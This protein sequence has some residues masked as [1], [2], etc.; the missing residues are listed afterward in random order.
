M[1]FKSFTK[2]DLRIR[3][4][5]DYICSGVFV[6]LMLSLF[7]IKRIIAYK[8]L[9]AGMISVFKHCFSTR[10][11]SFIIHGNWIASHSLFRCLKSLGLFIKD[12]RQM[13]RTSALI[14]VMVSSYCFPVVQN[15]NKY[16][17]VYKYDHVYVVLMNGL[18]SIE[19]GMVF[20]LD[21]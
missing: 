17:N 19:I 16:L 20:L 13:F 2:E 11:L 5:P 12:T 14:I 6:K 3:L 7:N 10:E 1:S 18:L 9:K 21:T 4:W 15:E 8:T